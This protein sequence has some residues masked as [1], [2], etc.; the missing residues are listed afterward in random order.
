MIQ[1]DEHM[2]QKGWNHQLD[3]FCWNF[4]ELLML[5]WYHPS[6]RRTAN[7]WQAI[8]TTLPHLSNEKNPGCLG[9]R[10]DY[11]TQLYRDYNKPL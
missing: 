2:F 7:P 8:F 10:G 1:F 6:E 4:A 11:T 5:I 3:L 9:Y